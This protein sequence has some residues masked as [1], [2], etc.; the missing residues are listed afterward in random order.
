[1]GRIGRV[2][3]IEKVIPGAKN[4]LSVGPEAPVDQRVGR[5]K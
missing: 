1:M 2:S 4:N 5:L 3:E